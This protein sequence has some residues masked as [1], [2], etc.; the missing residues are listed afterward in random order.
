M[1]I[2]RIDIKEKQIHTEEQ[3]IV[4]R[5]LAES[6][7]RA[8]C[9][10]LEVGS[11]C[12]DSTVLLGKVVQ[13]NGGQLYC[14]DWWKGNEGTELIEIAKKTD[15]FSFFWNR[16]CSEGLEDVV[17]PIRSRSDVAV[18]ILK[19]NMF[20]LV[21]IDADHRYEPL[22]NDI[23]QYAPLVKRKGGILCGHD[24]EGRIS[25]YDMSFLD[26]GRDKDIY[27]SV[28]CG[29][30]LAVGSAFK[31]FSINHAIWSVRAEADGWKPTN[32]VYPGIEDKRQT[33]LPTIGLSKSYTFLRYDR[34]VYAVPYSLSSLDL[35]EERERERDEI[36][37]AKDLN[38]AESI[39]GE[40]IYTPPVLLES[41]KGFNLLDFDGSI[42]A[43]KTMALGHVDI[44]RADEKTLKMYRQNRELFFTESVDKVKRLV[45]ESD[46]DSRIEALQSELTSR[47]GTIQ[48]QDKELKAKESRIIEL[49][50]NIADRDA[51]IEA[52]QREIT[53]RD[54]IIQKQ[55]K[56]LKTKESRIIELQNNIADRD[57]RIEALQREIVEKSSDIERQRK[58]IKDKDS[59]IEALQR[60]LTRIKAS[61][62]FRLYKFIKGRDN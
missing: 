24:C 3:R 44:I 28:H 11:W 21:F 41:Y 10:F 51:R 30:V 62:W 17:I 20:D 34:L 45:D 36:I 16:I 38:E 31:N 40:K 23:K 43:L 5:I 9:K 33:P 13:E 56:E 15:I 47:D 50:N 54:S 18:E 42:Y 7:A 19:D 52:L 49:Q 12:G 61:L 32:L 39:V 27:Q 59:K 48:G 14:V 55:D 25:D 29:V 60:E 57:A 6:A 4:L 35:R 58:D 2:D 26:A 1:N 37:K 46:R 53:S 8:G 22:A